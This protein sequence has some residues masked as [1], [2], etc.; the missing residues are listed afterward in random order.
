MD[1]PK[2]FDRHPCDRAAERLRSSV[3]SLDAVDIDVENTE[4]FHVPPHL[5]RARGEESQ[6]L[7]SFE[8]FNADH[9]M[10]VEIG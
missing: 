7:G 1:V 5:F 10:L 2:L 8:D 9:V 6:A 4:I 3:G